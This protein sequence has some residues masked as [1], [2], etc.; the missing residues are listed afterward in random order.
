MKSKFIWVF[1]LLTPAACGFAQEQP[2]TITV[3]GSAFAEIIPDMATVRM[4]IVVRE[5]TLSSAQEKAASVASKVLAL[6]DELD[7]DRK[8]VDT[9]GASVRTDYRWNR[10]T[11]EPEF[12]GYIAERRITVELD[13]LDKLGAL[14][15][16]AVKADVNTVSPPQMDSSERKAVYRQALAAAAEDARAN[17]ER[18]SEALGTRLGKVI[19]V[20]TASTDPRLP[21]PYQRSFTSA[22][23][24]A[25]EMMETYNAAA[26]SIDASVTVVF[27]L[28]D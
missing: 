4:S 3:E 10:D 14:V 19:V 6:A 17:A 23:V 21:M 25:D 13:D 1:L 2:R 26:L 15:E 22:G 24:G 20:Q 16:G 18:L 12:R 11:E 5:P 27:E 8:K 9:T 7:I 28:T